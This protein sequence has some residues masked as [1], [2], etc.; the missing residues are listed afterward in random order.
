MRKRPLLVRTGVALMR[1]VAGVHAYVNVDVGGERV[2]ILE[3]FPNLARGGRG[4]RTTAGFLR[5]GTPVRPVLLE[6]SSSL[7][8]DI[9]MKHHLSDERGVLP[10][11]GQFL[12]GGC[13]RVVA[14][15]A[16]YPYQLLRSVLQ[17]QHCPY[18]GIQDAFRQVPSLSP[19]RTGWNPHVV[20]ACVHA[21]RV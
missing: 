10:G 5:T 12:A 20:D 18:R 1:V 17:Q 14:L 19:S 11:W 9:K 13:S 4:R 21:L 7:L 16:T 6:A 15:L 2:Q 3:R 8:H